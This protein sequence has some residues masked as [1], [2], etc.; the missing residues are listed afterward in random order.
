MTLRLR[1]LESFFEGVVPSIIATSSADGVPNISYLSH[2]ILVDDDHVGLSNQF[3]TTTSANLAANPEATILLVEGSHG[4]Q[5]RLRARYERTISDGPLFARLATQLN[6]SSAQVGMGGIMRLRGV[7]IF[8]VTEIS[9]YPA[10]VPAPV[11][12]P[13]REPYLETTA[14]LSQLFGEIG[15]S[16]DQAIDATLDWMRDALGCENAAV[17]LADPRNAT[18]TTAGTRGYGRSGIG[19]EIRFGEGV[20]GSAASDRCL[21]K[22]S[23]MSRAR[24]YSAAI[25]A[26]SEDENRTRRIEPPFEPMAMSQIALPMIANGEVQGVLAAES[27][28]RLAFTALHEAALWVAA[29]RLASCI[30]LSELLAGEAKPAPVPV[31]ERQDGTEAFDVTYYR[32]DDSV[33]IAGQYIIKGMAGRLLVHMLRIALESGRIA[34]TNRELRLSP[35]LRLPEYKDN[36]ET[37]LL[38]LRRRLSDKAS[39]IQLLPM[40]RGQVMLRLDGRPTL[41]EGD[42]RDR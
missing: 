3:F 19:S 21:V 26:S 1:D 20:F 41:R 5:C 12:A 35:S 10:P 17:F 25:G 32:F 16:L 14:E 27:S 6:A 23:D 24:R 2:V 8:R 4:A 34:F 29:Q 9:L 28:R 40:G 36:L 37:R 22:I 31:A 13:R 7:D 15:G 30:L 11:E 42:M 33:F 39:P 18:L 38:L